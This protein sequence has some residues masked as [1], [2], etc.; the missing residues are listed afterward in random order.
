M[1]PFGVIFYGG[2]GVS[3]E[4]AGIS[5]ADATTISPSLPPTKNRGPRETSVQ[6]LFK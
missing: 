4:L 3:F 2:I 6:L 5:K 1:T